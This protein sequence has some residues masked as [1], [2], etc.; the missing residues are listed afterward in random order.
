MK[1]VPS[2]KGRGWPGPDSPLQNSA[3]CIG[4]SEIFAPSSLYPH[5]WL[6]LEE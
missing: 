3:I 1:G 6:V 5:L 4:H 2:A